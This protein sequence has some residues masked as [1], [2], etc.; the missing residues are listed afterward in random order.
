M[1]SLSRQY[2]ISLKYHIAVNILHNV[3]N[4][5]FVDYFMTLSAYRPAVLNVGYAY[6]LGYAVRAQTSL[7]LVTKSLSW[8]ITQ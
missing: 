3:F 4:C 2:A 6:A 1:K 5:S 8:L 7:D